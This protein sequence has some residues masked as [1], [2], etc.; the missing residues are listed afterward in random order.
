MEKY[1]FPLAGNEE[2]LPFF[3]F[4]SYKGVIDKRF[5]ERDLP[6]IPERAPF[7]SDWEKWSPPY[8][9]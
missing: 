8:E 7:T 3:L 2:N 5:P 6:E 1:I 4:Y 9:V